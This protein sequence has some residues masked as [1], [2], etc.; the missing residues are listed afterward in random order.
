MSDVE[1]EINS[2][3]GETLALSTIIGFV[4]FRMVQDHPEFMLAV[5]TGFE[6]AA[7]HVENM[8]IKFG[9][10]VPPEHL[11]KSLGMVEQLR[12]M[13]LGK[14]TKPRRGV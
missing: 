12:A 1:H 11:V 6:D 13:S 5:S 4:L 14:H 10:T 9:K 2:L 3:H 8:A 7:S